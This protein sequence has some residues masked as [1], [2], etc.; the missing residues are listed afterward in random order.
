[1]YNINI[2]TV[3]FNKSCETFFKGTVLDV[4]ALKFFLSSQY[5]YRF[6]FLAS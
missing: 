1:M 3:M 6:N 2:I 4:S 5:F